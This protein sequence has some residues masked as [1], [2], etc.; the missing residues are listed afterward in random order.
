M[1]IVKALIFP[2]NPTNSELFVISKSRSKT[3][4]EFTVFIGENGTRKSYLL[5]HILDES[6][7]AMASSDSAGLIAG[8]SSGAMKFSRLPAKIITASAAPTDRF[9][10]KP[11]AAD[12]IRTSKYNVSYYSYIGP[13]TANNILSRNQSVDELIATILEKPSTLKEKRKFLFGITEQLQLRPDFEF[14]LDVSFMFG[15]RGVDQFLFERVEE[16]RGK[17][18]EQVVAALT[19]ALEFSTTPT[20]RQFS[21]EIEGKLSE[22]KSNRTSNLVRSRK[23]HAADFPLIVY[24]NCEHGTIDTNGISFAA[25]SW[26]IQIGYIRPGRFSFHA[27]TGTV[28]NQEDLSAGQWSLFSTMVTLAL[29]VKNDTLL[30]IDEP[31]TGLHP[32]W[33]RT[34]LDTIKR[35]LS[36]VK[37]CHVLI[38]THSPLLLSSLDPKV[39]NLITLSR[40]PDSTDICARLESVPFGW[41]A[42]VILQDTFDLDD[43]RAPGLTDLVDDALALLA[44]GK[45]NNIS[46]LK[47][48]VKKLAP[49]YKSLPDED[50][51][52]GVVKSIMNVI[53]KV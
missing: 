40:D 52:K 20:G 12:R 3:L 27:A 48:L 46:Q 2:F 10:S 19:S 31:E 1:S 28:L 23:Q 25:L 50:I 45:G 47:D 22:H 42:S 14:G 38:A 26:A 21:R 44:E 9:P 39:S 7:G 32:A 33:Q 16:A 17:R 35:A 24:V 53:G 8:Q 13:R 43:A 5:R 15:K 30:L 41:D 6:L 51:G 11:A 29:S 34:F 36:H 49:Y 18:S 37:G 4:N